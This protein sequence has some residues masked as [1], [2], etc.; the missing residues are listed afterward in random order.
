MP[1]FKVHGPDRAKKVFVCAGSLPEC[2]DGCLKKLQLPGSADDYQLY[3]DSDGTLLDDSESLV[4]LSEFSVAQGHHLTLIVMHKSAM[5]R[6]R[7]ETS[8]DS[9]SSSP[10]TPSSTRYLSSQS[11]SPPNAQ[12]RAS[13]N[14]LGNISIAGSVAVLKKALNSTHQMKFRNL[15]KARR[16]AT[17]LLV[18]Q[19][20]GKCLDGGLMRKV[21]ERIQAQVPEAFLISIG[22]TSASCFHQF[23]K[24]LYS[25]VNY[26]NETDVTCQRPSRRRRRSTTVDNPDEPEDESVPNLCLDTN[27]CALGMWDRVPNVDDADE[28]EEVRTSLL[29][30]S[31]R[32]QDDP[33]VRRDVALTY[34]LQRQDFNQAR[35]AA[36]WRRVFGRWPCLQYATFFFI[37][38]DTLMGKNTVE[39]WSEEFGK[40]DN[41]IGFMT[42]LSEL[43]N[44]GK[45]TRQSIL[46]DY[47]EKLSEAEAAQE[48]RIPATTAIVPLTIAYFKE[49]EDNFFL[50]V[51]NFDLDQEFPSECPLLLVQGASIFD[52][53]A[54][55]AVLVRKSF[56]IKVDNFLHGSLVVLLSYFVLIFHI[57]RRS[58]KLWSSYKVNPEFQLRV[59][60]KN[61]KKLPI[62]P[63]VATLAGKLKDFE[64]TQSMWVL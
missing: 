19:L 24:A 42:K 6:T 37:H 4:T 7:S 33:S 36:N 55:F 31:V 45:D 32:S 9:D 21:C 47:L 20:K 5:W 63:S 61:K 62:N 41:F 30:C 58:P 18:A 26:A 60:Q 14:S 1:L 50:I 29:Q 59:D 13:T 17:K 34:D 51:E 38:A 53:D 56:L 48:S 54:R 49:R 15:T 2:L 28:Q 16:E 57:P 39:V 11:Q 35:T 27:G 52:S 22:T 25:A 46:K 64:C 43:S 3:D 44:P 12:P 10:S 40:R 8:S 23:V